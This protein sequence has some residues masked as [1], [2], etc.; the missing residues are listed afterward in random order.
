MGKHILSLEVPDVMDRCIIRVI[1]ISK[2][3]DVLPVKCPVLMI[4]PPGFN[5]PIKIESGDIVYPGF[6]ANL[7]ACDLGLQKEEC[8][9]VY[10]YFQDGIYIIRYSV[11][12]NDTVYV[13]YNHLRVTDIMNKY[14]EVLCC[15]DMKGCNYENEEKEKISMLSG[16]RAYLDAAKAEV[17]WCHHPDKGMSLYNY[18]NTI[19]Q[20]I[21][22]KWCGCK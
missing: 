6:T 13:E 3:D 10:S 19:L 9:K 5:R 21:R 8:G 18:A 16:F 2:Y 17:E 7:T 12:P 15:L 20:K 1:D 11:S 14:Y 4:T 22:C